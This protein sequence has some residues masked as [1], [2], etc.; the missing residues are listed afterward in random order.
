MQFNGNF[1]GMYGQLNERT[2]S[3]LGT[4]G[5]TNDIARLREYRRRLRFF[6]G[7]HRDPGN[8]LPEEVD[9]VTINVAGTLVR[10]KAEFFAKRGF[11]VA[12]FDDPTTDDYEPDSRAFVKHALDDAWN[13]NNRKLLVLNMALMG[14]ITGDVF[15]RCSW[16]EGDAITAPFPRVELLPSSYVFPE[17]IGD[18]INPKMTRV[19]IAWTSIEE[20]KASRLTAWGRPR[21]KQEL[22]VHREVWTDKTREVYRNDTRVESGVN[23]FGVIPIV[24]IANT[25][26]PGSFYGMS[27]IAELIALNQEI[28]EKSTDLSDI[29]DHFATPITVVTGAKAGNLERNPGRIW[30]IPQGEVKNLQSTGDMATSHKYLDFLTSAMHMVSGVPSR[31]ANGDGSLGYVSGV[32]LSLQFGPME[33]MREAKVTA[34]STGIH[35]MNA[36]MLRALEMMEPEFRDKFSKL[37]LKNRYRTT[38]VWPSPLPQDE[39]MSLE[40]AKTRLELGLSTRRMEI[41]RLG[42]GESDADRVV[43]EVDAERE[44]LAMMSLKLGVYQDDLEEPA[45]GETPPGPGEPGENKGNPDPDRPNPVRQGQRKS[46][47]SVKGA[48][49]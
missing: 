19:T 31:I 26:M 34:Y 21:T 48:G 36:I 13:L 17:F 4:Y 2:Y 29:V 7:D 8:K 16:S 30:S 37:P 40:A 47:S 14:G 46:M 5:Y 23:P 43:A 35:R 11:E 45:D 39:L 38:T 6:I 25:A 42:G 41:I 12:L 49:R 24:H 10:R 22:V 32:S 20:G 9:P 1:E 18:S 28:N 44:K 3:A 27:D 33:D 15:L